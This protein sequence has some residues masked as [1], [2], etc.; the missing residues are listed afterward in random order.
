MFDFL[1]ENW[2]EIVGALFALVYLFFSI[3]QN[4]WLWLCGILTSLFYIY[5]FA[6]EAFYAD[7]G[8]Q[9]YYLFVSVYG[10]I[11]WARGGVHHNKSELPVCRLSI[12]SIMR[13][14]VMHSVIYLVILALLLFLPAW[15]DVPSS[16]LPYLDALT[17][18]GGIVA[19]WML[20][21]KYLENWIIWIAVDFISMGMYIYKGLTVTSVLFAVYTFAAIIGYRA[22]LKSE[23][24]VF[25][26]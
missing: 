25:V 17:T 13:L 7:M 14:I 16:S 8:L 18:S 15:L 26:R 24:K 23:H 3:R 11:I 9:V 2:I 10:W 19:T 5:V 4:I 12:S 22:W 20:A 6:K 21:K 1:I